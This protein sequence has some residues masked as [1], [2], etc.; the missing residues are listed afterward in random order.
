MKEVL[1][2]RADIAR[3]L[4]VDHTSAG[5]LVAKWPV[6][7]AHTQLYGRGKQHLYLESDLRPFMDKYLADNPA[8]NVKAPS[9]PV[10]TTGL[11]A[12]VTVLVGHMEDLEGKLNDMTRATLNTVT[13]Q[14]KAVLE[15]IDA[16]RGTVSRIVS[17]LGV[18]L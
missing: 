1:L 17:E 9:V 12:K 14:N 8:K 15:A 2:S 6:K 13:L 10:V 5:R 16:L 4:A 18:K 7:P 3:R 11:E